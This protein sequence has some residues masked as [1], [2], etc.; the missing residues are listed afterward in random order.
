MRQYK[1]FIVNCCKN[2]Y[3]LNVKYQNV[4]LDIKKTL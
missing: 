2:L 1:I 3:F 4:K